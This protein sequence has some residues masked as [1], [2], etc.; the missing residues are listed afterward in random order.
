MKTKKLDNTL[1]KKLSNAVLTL[2]KDKEQLNKVQKSY[3]RYIKFLTKNGLL[4]PSD[5]G[6]LFS[7]ISDIFQQYKNS[8]ISKKHNS[9]NEVPIIS[10]KGLIGGAKY[11]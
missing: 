5:S 9:K 7:K 4:Y 8:Y 2:I 3:T 6:R 1:E 11:E 10:G